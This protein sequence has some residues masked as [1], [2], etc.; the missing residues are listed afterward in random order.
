MASDKLDVDTALKDGPVNLYNRS[1][2][3]EQFCLCLVGQSF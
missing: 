2:S 1:I 3:D